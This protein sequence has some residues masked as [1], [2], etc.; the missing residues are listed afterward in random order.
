MADLKI[1]QLTALLGS[2]A[3]DT[4]VVPDHGGPA[5]QPLALGGRDILVD[6]VT[7]ERV[8]ERQRRLGCQ[9]LGADQGAGRRD[10]RVA[11][12]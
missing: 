9:Q 10:H 4:D 8:D 1:S 3:A 5:V 2:A 7:H 12:Q 11:G 6:R